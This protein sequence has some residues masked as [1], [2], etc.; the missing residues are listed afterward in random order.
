MLASLRADSWS[1][2]ALFTSR[3]AAATSCGGLA[4]RI[5]TSTTLMP[6]SGQTTRQSTGPQG[7]GNGE[8]RAPAISAD[9]RY[10]AFHSRATNLVAGDENGLNDVFLRDRVAGTIERVSIAS[11]VVAPQPSQVYL[12]YISR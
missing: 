2:P 3:K 10:V 12:G 1:W 8:S 6:T 5:W 7:G 11:A 9:G 4:E